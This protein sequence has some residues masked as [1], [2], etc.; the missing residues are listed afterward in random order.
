MFLKRLQLHNIYP[1]FWLENALT[2]LDF[3]GGFLSGVDISLQGHENNMSVV[4]VLA[5]GLRIRV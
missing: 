3:L 4:I 1:C 2:N 5:P